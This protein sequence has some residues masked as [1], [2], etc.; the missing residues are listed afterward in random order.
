M[1]EENNNEIEQ[2]ETPE[3]ESTPEIIEV[4]WEKVEEV[5]TLRAHLVNLE[6]RLSA[7]CLN[8]EKSKR[9]LLNAITESESAMYASAATLK[10]NEGIPEQATYELKLPSVTGEKGYFIRKE[11]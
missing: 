5:Y 11:Q 4:E 2:V 10:D 6:S 9:Q 1:S 3:A 8:F 7:M